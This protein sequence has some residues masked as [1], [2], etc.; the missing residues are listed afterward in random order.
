MKLLEENIGVNLC[1]LEIGKECL[2]MPPK[3]PTTKEKI[4]KLDL[5]KLQTLCIKGHYQNSK[6][7][8]QNVRK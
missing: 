2:D 5:S 7:I 1:D 4:Q 6:T 8:M 3:L